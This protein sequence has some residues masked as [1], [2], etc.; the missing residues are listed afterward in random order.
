MKHAEVFI[1]LEHVSAGMLARMSPERRTRVLK[2]VAEHRAYHADMRALNRRLAA[3]TEKLQ[4]RWGVEL[5][6]GMGKA[7]TAELDLA[8]KAMAAKGFE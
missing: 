3:C 6:P 4:N 1:E 7:V 8:R 5:R 2:M